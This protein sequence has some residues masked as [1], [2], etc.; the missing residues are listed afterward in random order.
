LSSRTVSA[1]LLFQ[2]PFFQT[3]ARLR[4]RLAL[5]LGVTATEWL[6][7]EDVY[8]LGGDHQLRI[9][10]TFSAGTVNTL[11]AWFYGLLLPR[12]NVSLG[13]FILA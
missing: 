13:D 12:G 6:F 5:G 8:F 9:T 10:A 2:A 7:P 1:D 3:A 11:T 4:Y